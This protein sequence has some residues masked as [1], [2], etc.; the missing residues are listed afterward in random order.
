MSLER[1]MRI[2]VDWGEYTLHALFECFT[3]NVLPGYI[4]EYICNINQLYNYR[5]K[6]RMSPM[7]LEEQRFFFFNVY[8]FR[9]TSRN[10]S[11]TTYLTIGDIIKYLCRA[12]DLMVKKLET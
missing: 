5:L 2:W 3:G 4:T 1:A 8:S 10:L 6:K 11:I 12:I 7:I 9:P